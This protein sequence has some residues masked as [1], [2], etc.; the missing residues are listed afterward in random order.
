[1]RVRFA[2]ER[3]Q[4]GARTADVTLIEANGRFVVARDERHR[5]VAAFKKSRRVCE[6]SQCRVELPPAIR[7]APASVNRVGLGECPASRW[8][9][10]IDRAHRLAQQRLVLLNE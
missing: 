5:T 9:G 6:I 10:D 4:C 3:L 2:E 7:D 8:S 1:M